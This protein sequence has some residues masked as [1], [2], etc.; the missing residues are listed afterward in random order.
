MRDLRVWMSKSAAAVSF[1]PPFPPLVNGVRRAQVTT[2]SSG[3]L[4]SM[5]SRPRGMSASEDARWD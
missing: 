4:E 1:R 5:L 2:M 3:D